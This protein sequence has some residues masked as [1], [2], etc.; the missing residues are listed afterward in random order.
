MQP[1]QELFTDGVFVLPLLPPLLCAGQTPLA[2]AITRRGSGSGSATNA[3]TSASSMSTAKIVSTCS[4]SV[5]GNGVLRGGTRSTQSLQSRSDE[6]FL[7]LRKSHRGAGC[8]PREHELFDG[9]SSIAPLA[10]GPDDE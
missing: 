4:G 10:N 1:T 9:G 6:G 8:L 7:C 5:L 2:E 3:S